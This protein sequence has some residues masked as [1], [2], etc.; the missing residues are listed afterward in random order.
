[1]EIKT[2]W[3]KLFEK[4][5]ITLLNEYPN[6]C[7]NLQAYDELLQFNEEVEDEC[8][9]VYYNEIFQWFIIGNDEDAE[10]LKE[11]AVDIADDIQWSDIL[12]HYILAV[13][14][15]GAPW[16]G[17]YTTLEFD[18]STDESLKEVYKRHYEAIQ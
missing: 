8:G 14:H 2:T 4:V 7:Q 13:K 17:V 15:Y 11:H 1:M 6:I 3:D 10:W 12:G 5:N 16:S 9:E 18:D